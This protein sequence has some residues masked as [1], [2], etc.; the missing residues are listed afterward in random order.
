LDE[1]LAHLFLVCPFAIQCWAWINVQ[2]D[3]SLSPF[4]ILESF[5]AQ[6]QV[7]FFMEIIILMSWA[8]WKIR[9]DNIF[10]QINPSFQSA[11]DF[12]RAELQLLVLRIRRR[13]FQGLNQWIASLS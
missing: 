12:F 4:Q 10:R 13:S 7:P 9:N 3:Q 8:I 1:S 5:K 11:K 2:V 6:L